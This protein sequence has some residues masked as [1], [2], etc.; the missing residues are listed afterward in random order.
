MKVLLTLGALLSAFQALAS[1]PD[2]TKVIHY[3]APTNFL[4]GV[5]VEPRS[6]PGDNPMALD[7]PPILEFKERYDYRHPSEIRFNLGLACA[8]LGPGKVV[9]FL[10]ATAT[11]LKE[12][13]EAQ[14]KGKFPTSTSVSI[15][16]INRLTAVSF[17][18]KRPPGPV[19]P[20]FLHFCWLQI[21]T[22]IVLK[23]TA[24][25]SDIKIFQ[26]ETNS[27]QSLEIDKVSLLRMLG[28][29][30]R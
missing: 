20:Y 22:N 6:D 26:S 23:I 29:A 11:S 12:D 8:Y 16:K 3:T 21:E 7:G 9:Q 10:P 27:L 2:S 14:Y 19:Q 25:S 30:S 15:G 4:G 18:G 13:M 28:S 17:T 24:V 5:A 1:P